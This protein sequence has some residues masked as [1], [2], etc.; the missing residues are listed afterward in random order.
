MK[1][2]SEKKRQKCG[3]FL[4]ATVILALAGC[5]NMIHDLHDKER[6]GG[7]RP[8]VPALLNGQVTL[9]WNYYQGLDGPDEQV[10]VNMGLPDTPLD[11]P[12]NH[13]WFTPVIWHKNRNFD[14][15]L[16]PGY[17]PDNVYQAGDVLGAADTDLW[18]EWYIT[19][20]PAGSV[21][22]WL[23]QAPAG[24]D[25][26]RVPVRWTIARGN[27]ER[28]L[29][30]IH[31]GARAV[32]LD[33]R[34][35]FGSVGDAIF[36]SVT[37]V[38]DADGALGGDA[39]TG[40]GRVVALALPDTV[41]EIRDYTYPDANFAGFTVLKGVS[42]EGMK[43][44]GDT[45]F[46]QIPL[47]GASFPNVTAIGKYAFIQCTDLA[48]IDC[49]KTVS[50]GDNAFAGCTNLK[51]ADFPLAE[52]IVQFTFSGCISLEELR[53]PLVESIGNRS[54]AGCSAL[55]EAE[56]PGITTGDIGTNAFDSSG[57]ESV[58][59]PNAR[60]AIRAYAFFECAYLETV[61][62]PR[63]TV[64]AEAAFYNCAS[65]TSITMGE[66]PP[67]LNGD[68]HFTGSTPDSFTIRVPI[69]RVT[70]YASWKGT[71]YP[72]SFNNDSNIVIEGY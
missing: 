69:G 67:A 30:E 2:D 56:F 16:E 29:T 3:F 4:V 54:F 34:N 11:G 43:R 32:Q 18:A 8:E 22:G 17:D 7:S 58:S 50:I 20:Q 27:W 65:L 12:A 14:R 6:D 1:A 70:A 45:A 35:C 28:L 37:G 26:V 57:L 13:P 41:R 19:E 9:H 23:A 39:Q 36:D 72:A 25:P 31:G 63:I 40:K 5:G 49:P 71:T 61:H 42:G 44:I 68:Y 55:K 46:K 64:I 21:A 62:I 53:F 52:A 59:F 38:F 47:T 66:T 51:K 33:M 15:P 60:G 48:D 24:P 10:A